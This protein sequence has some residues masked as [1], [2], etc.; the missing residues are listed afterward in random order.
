MVTTESIL[1]TLDNKLDEVDALIMQLPLQESV[2]KKL[3]SRVYE[4]WM[5]V[6]E[7][8]ELRATDFG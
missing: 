5:D 3:T 6:E 7:E 1:E 4:L 2:K 8:I